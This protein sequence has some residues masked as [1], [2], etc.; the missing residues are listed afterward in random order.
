MK[1]K[2]LFVDDEPHVL[3]G[4][5]VAFRH[6]PYQIMTA[7]SADEAL[8]LLDQTAI[9]VV[10]SDQQMPGMPGLDFLRAVR[11][12]F[13]ETIRIMLTGQADPQVDDAVSR[14]HIFRFLTKP[15]EPEMLRE[16]LDAALEQ[17][18]LR[19]AERSRVRRP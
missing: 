19:I 13:P 17:W 8:R 10:V 11:R 15:C 7:Q 12:G 14:G 6:A 18:R 9:D 5:K 1:P 4:I 16:C 2:L 3:E